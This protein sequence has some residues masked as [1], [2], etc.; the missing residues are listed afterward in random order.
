MHAQTYPYMHNGSMK[1]L[2]QV[3]DFYNRGGGEG[4]GMKVPGQTLPA[5]PLH[6]SETEINHIIA[7]LQALTDR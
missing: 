3:L 2:Q 6:L 1:T 7:F 4:L 5:H